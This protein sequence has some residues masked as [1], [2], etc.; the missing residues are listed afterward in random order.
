MESY[1]MALAV[2]D[3]VSV[4]RTW[5]IFRLT[6]SQQ[7]WVGNTHT[8]VAAREGLVSRGPTWNAFT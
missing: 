4:H 2:T 6:H 8:K 5:G 7:L 3:A 1:V